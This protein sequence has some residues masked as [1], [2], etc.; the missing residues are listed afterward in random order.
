MP[1]PNKQ[2]RGTLHPKKETIGN[3]IAR[4][5]KKVEDK[6]VAVVRRA[7]AAVRTVANSL[8]QRPAP[9]RGRRPPLP[10]I[11]RT[12]GGTPFTRSEFLM[13][14][15]SNTAF[16]I[17]MQEELHLGN[18]L[19]FPMLSTQILAYEEYV[20]DSLSFTYVPSSGTAISS[21]A[22]GRVML[23]ITYDTEDA[24]ITSEIALLNYG[25]N[26]GQ[27]P[28]APY[29][30]RTVK[31]NQRGSILSKLY[32]D[33]GTEYDSSDK[34]FHSHGRVIVAVSG[35]AANGAIL[36]SIY[37]NY[38]IRAL[39]PRLPDS[40][41]LN[42]GFSGYTAWSRNSSASNPS[43]LIIT[44]DMTANSGQGRRFYRLVDN[45][46]TNTIVFRY[47]GTYGIMIEVTTFAAGFAVNYT[48][49]APILSGMHNTTFH[50]YNTDCYI[51]GGKAWGTDATTNFFYAWA[52]S[53]T[54]GVGGGSLSF[55]LDKAGSGTAGVFV[56]IGLVSMGTSWRPSTTLVGVSSPTP[57]SLSD[58]LQRLDRVER[59]GKDEA[60]DDSPDPGATYDVVAGPTA[61]AAAIPAGRRNIR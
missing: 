35:N 32:V 22:Q 21:Q 3:K 55:D 9:T 61:S 2:K 56:S 52:T 8:V 25:A 17:N 20:L 39:I 37:V 12:S 29:E 40:F 10:G 53:T 48:P 51:S 1:Q 4:A 11:P 47:P 33:H 14:V 58:I 57:P 16:N 38:H 45:G 46:T 19:V 7:G 27:R 44:K 13:D 23:C 50:T 5:E 18:E 31:Y 42:A 36:G 34:A 43:K 41:A 30:H 6:A 59:C 60:E 15:Q 24:P 26:S 49:S 28:F 54:S